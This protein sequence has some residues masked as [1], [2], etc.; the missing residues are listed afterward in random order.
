[1]KTTTLTLPHRP[2][3]AAS[4]AQPNS[5]RYLYSGCALL[6]LGLT[7]LGFR[8]FYLHGQTA[9]GADL[10]ASTKGLLI[11][12]GVAMTLWIVLF[13]VQPLLIAGRKRRLHMS[14]GI[15]GAALAACIVPLGVCAAVAMAKAEP[16]AMH[17]GGLNARQF[18]VVQFNSLLMFA[19]FVTA[20][21][22]NRRRPEIHRPMLFLATLATMGAVFGRIAPLRQLVA[23]TAWSTSFGPYFFPLIVGLVFL[24][25]K[26]A[27]TRAFDRWLTGGLAMLVVI[28]LVAMKIARTDFWAS[29]G[30]I[31][32]R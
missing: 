18:L 1:M 12:H 29:I 24:A 10:V 9:R 5:A 21:I 30:Q 8:N 7:F 22:V 26:T 19:T 3:R 16:L 11:A 15:F 17:S 28:D 14:L 32:V 31:L 25:T 2:T 27:L 20:G 6:L 4:S 23:G 13:A